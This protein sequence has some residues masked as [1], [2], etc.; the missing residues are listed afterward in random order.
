M[1]T[2]K[3]IGYLLGR[4][5][6]NY[7][8]P[9]NIT[10]SSGPIKILGITFN[11]G[12]NIL[13]SD[14]LENMYRSLAV[15]VDKWKNIF[16]SSPWRGRVMV[17]NQ[18]IAPK[19]WYALKILPVTETYIKRIQCLLIDLFWAGRKH[20][21]TEE[22]LVLLI[23]QGGLGL[24]HVQ[25][26]I[27]MFRLMFVYKYL[28]HNEE[29]KWFLFIKYQLS[30]YRSAGLTWQV[31]FTAPSHHCATLSPFLNRVLESELDSRFLTCE[32]A[33]RHCL[34]C[35]IGGDPD[36]YLPYVKCINWCSTGLNSGP[37]IIYFIYQ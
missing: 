20:W 7:E 14:N 22:H 35:E 25:S 24:V 28:Q 6:Q 3:S 5:R 13:D 34:Q 27:R 10:W 11:N 1:N 12:E 2:K 19:L 8:K 17:I 16:P 21:V 29:A 15:K 37:C 9:C 36:I 30:V 26:K 23:G 32:K 18:F 31:F 4:A 33:V